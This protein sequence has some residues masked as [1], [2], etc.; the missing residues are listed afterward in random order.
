MGGLKWAYSMSGTFLS[1]VPK[2]AGTAHFMR[3]GG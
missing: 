2:P 3:R 1:K